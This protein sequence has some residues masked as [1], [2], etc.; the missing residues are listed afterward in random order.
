MR[1]VIPGGSGQVGTLVARAFHGVGAEVIVLSRN[2]LGNQPWK[3]MPWDGKSLGPW[4][5]SLESAD[6]L[7]NLA[8]RS[9]NCRYHQVNRREI[10]ESRID[11]TRV[12]GQAVAAAAVPPRIWLQMSTATIYAHRHDAANEEATGIL[13][14]QEPNVPD[15]W[16]FSIEVAKAWE[17]EWEKADTPQTRK[18]ALRSA[19]VM[20]PDRGGVLDTLLGLVRKGLGGTSG[21]GQQY[22]SW[23]H[24]LDFVR[25]LLDCPHLFGMYRKTL[26]LLED[27]YSQ[28]AT[29]HFS[30][31][32]PLRWLIE[33]E[34]ESGIFNLA[35]PN[36]LPNAAFMRELRRAWGIR[37]GLPATRWMLE[38]G[39][40]FLRTETELVLKSRRV[41]PARLLRSGF[42]FEFPHWPEAA[43]DLCAR[44]RMQSKLS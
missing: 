33:H 21:D 10:L 24:E 9:V 25:A 31:G 27:V 22:V 41:V 35:A 40:F 20:S 19:M 17:R 11:S 6:A 7:L 28:L 14:G 29:C 16:R 15:T 38:I 30:V 36:P 18:V 32:G 34:T 8:G 23:I 5:K 42:T 44:W 13:G 39:A 3:E 43:R 4:T 12:I 37:V 2:P 26:V 1:I